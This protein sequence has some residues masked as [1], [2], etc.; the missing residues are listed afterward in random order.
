MRNVVL[1]AVPFLVGCAVETEP[2][3]TLRRRGV[4]S[5]EVTEAEPSRGATPTA[6]TTTTTGEASAR[7][8]SPA[9]GGNLPAGEAALT[10]TVA[11]LARTGTRYAPAAITQRKLPVVLALH[12]NGDDAA[13]FVV[14]S[15]LRALAD[16]EGFVLVAP[17]GVMRAVTVNGITTPRVAWD[18]YNGRANNADVQLF[19]T[20][21]DEVIASGSVDATKLVVYGYSQGGY[22]AVRYGKEASDRLSCAAVLAAGDS[23]GSPTAF[24]EKLRFSIQIGANDPARGNAANLARSLEAAGHVVAFR[25][26]AGAG[27]VPIPP[28][29]RTPLD[30]C[31]R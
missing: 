26:I 30:E 7:P 31:L 5:E 2:T 12:G 23:G 22:A 15:G 13:R 25:E 27:H 20:L 10:R 28:P 4:S 11:G 21:L 14:T 1:L 24:T 8:G 6:P 17:Q 29:A 16:S 18:A 9:P 19:D 3:G